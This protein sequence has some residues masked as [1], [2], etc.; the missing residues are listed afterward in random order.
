[1][2]YSLAVVVVV[3]GSSAFFAPD[4]VDFGRL[5]ARE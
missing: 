1:M 3:M 2:L 4:A 5:L